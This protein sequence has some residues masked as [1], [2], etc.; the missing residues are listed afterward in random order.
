MIP[1]VPA[2]LLQQYLL[3]NTPSYLF[4]AL[5]GDPYVASLKAAAPEQDLREFVSTQP[6]EGRS[7][8]RALQ[9][10]AALFVLFQTA[11]SDAAKIKDAEASKLPWALALLSLART[12]GP[13]NNMIQLTVPSVR[14]DPPIGSKDSWSFSNI[15]F[16]LPQ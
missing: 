2:H 9:T 8:R 12:L 16:E 1:E 3:A 15:N 11:A 7:A 13:K 6:T 4:K 14:G 10:Y 5:Q